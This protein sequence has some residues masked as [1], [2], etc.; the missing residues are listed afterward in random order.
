M[1][2][3][4]GIPAFP[5]P[6]ADAAQRAAAAAKADRTPHLL[7][8]EEVLL[9][10]N[11]KVLDLGNSG[12]LRHLGIG[13]PVPRPKAAA[14]KAAGNPAKPQVSDAQLGRMTGEQVRRAAAEGRIP[15]IGVRRR[16]W[17]QR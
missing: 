5:D 14:K 16:N 8:E 1:T 7:S 4:R 13:L 12:H 3:R 17:G 15:G 11:R 2:R 6:A 9:L 10:P